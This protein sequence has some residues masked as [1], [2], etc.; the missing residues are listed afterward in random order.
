MGSRQWAVGSA[1]VAWS[2]ALRSDVVLIPAKGTVP[3]SPTRKFG[4]SPGFAHRSCL[5]LHCL[6]PTAHCRLLLFQHAHQFRQRGHAFG[7]QQ[8]PFFL[9]AFHAILAG[10][11]GEALR[12]WGRRPASCGPRLRRPSAR[13][14]PFGRCSRSRRTPG[15]AP[16]GLLRIRLERPVERLDAA[17]GNAQL[18]QDLRRGRVG[19]LAGVAQL[20]DQALV[21]H[22]AYRLGEIA[23]RRSQSQYLQQCVGAVRRPN[24]ADDQ[25]VVGDL[26]AAETRPSRRRPNRE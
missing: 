8:D 18:L 19:F 10:G 24:R 7:H 17:F 21:Q 22:A 9:K 3:F 25:P 13:K 20:A 15:T 11:A 1:G 6:L 16:W 14:S 12:A 23:R 5:A 4:Q 26:F 2:G